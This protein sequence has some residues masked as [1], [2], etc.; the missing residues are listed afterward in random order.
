MSYA[1]YCPY[2][3]MG[4]DINHDDGQGYTEDELHSQDCH[5]CGEEFHYHTSV[6][7]RYRAY[8]RKHV[9]E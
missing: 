7:F 1:I 8:T 5:L 6:Y 4:Q 2:C 9:D 3:N